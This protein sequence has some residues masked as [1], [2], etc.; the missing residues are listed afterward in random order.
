MPTPIPRDRIEAIVRM[1]GVCPPSITWL[2]EPG[3]TYED[4]AEKPKWALI[5]A[6]FPGADIEKLQA[7]VIEYGDASM[8]REFA[9]TVP[10]ANKE[11]LLTGIGS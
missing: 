1:G 7:I 5:A 9:K 10:G 11:A 3:R 8:R 6:R 2:Q 4:L